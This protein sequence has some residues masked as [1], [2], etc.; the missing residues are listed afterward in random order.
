MEKRE[1]KEDLTVRAIDG[2]VVLSVSGIQIWL[3]EEAAGDVVESILL[4]LEVISRNNG[5]LYVNN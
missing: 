3:D 2:S 5:G 1:K 4:A